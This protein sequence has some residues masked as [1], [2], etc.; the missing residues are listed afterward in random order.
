MTGPPALP[1]PPPEQERAFVDAGRG[2]LGQTLVGAHD[3]LVDPPPVEEVTVPPE[4]EGPALAT[5]SLRA[6]T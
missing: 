5:Q 2:I 1:P 3:G 6:C 4:L